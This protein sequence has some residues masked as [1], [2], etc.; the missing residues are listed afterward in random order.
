MLIV[1]LEHKHCISELQNHLHWI[2]MLAG[3]LLPLSHF[4]QNAEAHCL[5]DL[6]LEK[7]RNTAVAGKLS[8]TNSTSSSDGKE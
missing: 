5:Q 3:E 7:G 2:F 4:A 8:T 1:S 6:L